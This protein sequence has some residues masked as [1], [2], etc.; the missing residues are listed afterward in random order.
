MFQEHFSVCLFMRQPALKI[1]QQE[2]HQKFKVVISEKVGFLVIFFILSY[3]I[4][5]CFN[6]NHV[7][8]SENKILVLGHIN[9]FLDLLIYIDEYLLFTLQYEVSLLS[10]SLTTQFP[11]LVATKSRKNICFPPIFLHKWQRADIL[12][13]IIFLFMIA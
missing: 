4:F 3:Y 2:M 6:G 11:F 9:L 10:L 8:Y 1:N 7:L 5:R 13:C 12:F